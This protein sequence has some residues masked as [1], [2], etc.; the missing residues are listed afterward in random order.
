MPRLNQIELILT[1]RMKKK[2]RRKFRKP[3]PM[4]IQQRLIVIREWFRKTILKGRKG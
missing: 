1:Q 2:I 3:Q 4:L